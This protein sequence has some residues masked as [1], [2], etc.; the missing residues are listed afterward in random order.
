MINKYE[1]KRGKSFEC[2][3]CPYHCVL[4]HGDIGLCLIREC[5]KEGIHLEGYGRVSSMAVDPIEKKPI[6]HYK[7]NSKVLSIGAWGCNLDC[8]YCQNISISKKRP[9]NCKYFSASAIS[10]MAQVRKCGG[11]CFTYNEPSISYEFLMDVS[12]KCH[13]SGLFFA[14]KTNGFVEKEPWKDICDVCDVMNIDWKL[15]YKGF[16]DTIDYGVIIL[17]NIESAINNKKLHV[18]ISVPVYNDTTVGEQDGIR[19]FLGTGHP[20]VPVHLLKVFPTDQYSN[21]PVEDEVILGFRDKLMEKSNFVYVENIFTEDG[22][23]ARDTV[24][25]KC[26][27]IVATRENFVTTITARCDVCRLILK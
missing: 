7:P 1:I 13:E 18:E 12:E 22:R 6:F 3:I 19:H 26:K 14:I 11:V 17:K 2:G 16:S 5:S 10:H 24:C 20:D 21:P 27:R 4:S 25:P 9:D 15:R 23:K 8:K